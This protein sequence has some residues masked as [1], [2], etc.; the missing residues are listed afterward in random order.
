[1]VIPI[2]MNNIGQMAHTTRSLTHFGLSCNKIQ[3]FNFKNNDQ[4]LASSIN[5]V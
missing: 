5:D 4:T 2:E 3:V 1:M